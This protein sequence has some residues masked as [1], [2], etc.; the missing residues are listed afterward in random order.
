VPV[1]AGYK[2]AKY[3][4]EATWAVLVT[5]TYRRGRFFEVGAEGGGGKNQI[6]LGLSLRWYIPIF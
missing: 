4:E 1:G 5:T 6:M 3:F 2:R